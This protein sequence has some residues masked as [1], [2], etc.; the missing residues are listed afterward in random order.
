[1]TAGTTYVVSYLAPDGHYSASV[2]AFQNQGADAPPLHALRSGE[3]GPNGVYRYGSG[4]FPSTAS[5]SNYWVDAVF[6][7][8]AP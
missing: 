8:T 1:V 6:T 7:T 2:G 5:T 3:D 4:G